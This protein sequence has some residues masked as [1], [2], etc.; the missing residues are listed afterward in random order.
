MVPT[1][2]AYKPVLIEAVN[3]DLKIRSLKHSQ[4]GQCE[5]SSL[6]LSLVFSFA[7]FAG[8]SKGG[9]TGSKGHQKN[10]DPVEGLVNWICRVHCWK[11]GIAAERFAKEHWL[12]KIEFG[13]EVPPREAGQSGGDLCLDVIDMDAADPDWAYEPGMTEESCSEDTDWMAWE[14]ELETEQLRAEAMEIGD[15]DEQE[16]EGGEGGARRPMRIVPV[17]VAGAPAAADSAAEH[18]DD[19]GDGD[20]GTDEGQGDAGMDCEGV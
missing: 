6:A 13:E 4:K 7:V 19:E 20:D 17:D 5:W 8:G 11:S 15:V 10:G 12:Q 9:K 2:S 1:T 3:I 14:D 16:G 18:A